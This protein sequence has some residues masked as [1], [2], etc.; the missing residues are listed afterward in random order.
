MYGT[1]MGGFS[2]NEY[3]DQPGQ[4]IGNDV[5]QE[6]NNVNEDTIHEYSDHWG[7]VRWHFYMMLGVMYLGMVFSN[8]QLSTNVLGQSLKGNSF[9]FWLKTAISWFTAL[10][11]IWTLIAPRLFPNRDFRVG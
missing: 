3:E 1:V 8:W 5:N 2:A 6:P 4:A 7:W 11:Y 9:V 10:A